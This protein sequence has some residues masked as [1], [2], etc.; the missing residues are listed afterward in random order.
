MTALHN[1]QPVNVLHTSATDGRVLTA[2]IIQDTVRMAVDIATA[3]SVCCS[4][5]A[6]DPAD[7]MTLNNVQDALVQK[8][9]DIYSSDTEECKPHGS[10]AEQL[11]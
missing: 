2:G 10:T 11:K 4:A 9:W 8:V 7:G 6:G 3:T 5:P 1:M